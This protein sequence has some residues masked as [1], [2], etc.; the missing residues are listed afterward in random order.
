MKTRQNGAAL[1]ELALILPLL[2]LLTF[3]TTEFGRAMYQYNTITKSVRDAVRYLSMQT[4]GTH[5]TEAQ[6]L[7]VYG[8]LA[9]T[10]TPLALG[11]GVS[12]VPTPTW[13]TTGSDPVINS[14]TVTVR[15]YA[16]R[17]LFP[18]VFGITFGNSGTFNYGDISATMRSPI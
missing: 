5:I 11:L 1:I 8:N 15:G 3:I 4:P 6:N 14:V 9:G 10:G 18:S 16:F 12:H 13:Q 7:V 17:S 2:L